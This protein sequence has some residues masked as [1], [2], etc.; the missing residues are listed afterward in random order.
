MSNIFQY[1]KIF[2]IHRFRTFAYHPQC[3]GETERFNC[4][5]EQMLACY[6]AEEKSDW[7]LYL[8]KFAYN[9][10]IHATTGLTPFEVVYGRR[11]KLPVDLM[12]Q[13]PE[14]GL[15]LDVDSYVKKTQTKLLRFYDIVAKNTDSKVSKFK[16][17]ADRNVRRKAYNLGDRVWLLNSA[18]KN[19]VSKKARTLYSS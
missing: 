19:G 7:S 6:V 2:D 8:E 1:L 16:F 15:N 14:L 4:T 13:V 12:F 10:S 18:K 9:T 3:D 5:I 17:Y 11:P